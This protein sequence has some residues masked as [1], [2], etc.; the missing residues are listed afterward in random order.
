MAEIPRWFPKDME[1]LYRLEPGDCPTILDPRVA[2]SHGGGACPEQHWGVLVDGR[3][4]YFRYRHG[5]ASVTLAPEWFEPG[6][7]PARD[8][9]TSIEEW[10]TAYEAYVAANGITDNIP[11]GVLPKLWLGT[12]DGFEV[13][14][15]NDGSFGSQ[16]ELDDAFTRCLDKVWGEPFDEEGW[17]VL[18]QTDW[19]K[20]QNPWSDDNLDDLFI[21]PQ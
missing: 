19:R 18:R 8:V 3:V 4:F 11:D 7:L 21:E 1:E 16:E 2:T 17:A 6:F 14:K 15:E 20:E 10:N 5:W 13:T 9:R 12:A